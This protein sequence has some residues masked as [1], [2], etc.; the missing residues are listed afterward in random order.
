[1]IIFGHAG[2][3]SISYLVRG[4]YMVVVIYLVRGEYTVVV[5]LVT[6]IVIVDLIVVLVIY[7]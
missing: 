2:V 5:F 1:M 7:H 3:V 6:F 4:E